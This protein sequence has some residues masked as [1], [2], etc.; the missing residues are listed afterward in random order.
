[1]STETLPETVRQSALALALNEKLKLM[2][3]VSFDYW[4][5]FRDLREKVSVQVGEMK[6]LFPEFTPHDE[7]QHLARLFSIADKLLG[8]ERYARMNPA[9]I[10]LLAVDRGWHRRRRRPR[11]RNWPRPDRRRRR[12]RSP[13][14][15]R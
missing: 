7:P 10:F 11:S 15:V 12:P 1:M 5:K 4:G 9:E 8:A 6:V 3:P 2:Q 13:V 14:G